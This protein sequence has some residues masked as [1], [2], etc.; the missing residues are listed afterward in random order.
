MIS[1]NVFLIL[2][3]YSLTLVFGNMLNILITDLD[4]G[5]FIRFTGKS[6]C[7]E[8]GNFS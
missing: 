8:L 5:K 4:T 3:K 1:H 2:K 6:K 7:T